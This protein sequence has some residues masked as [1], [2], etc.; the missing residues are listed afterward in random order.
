[1]SLMVILISSLVLTTQDS[2]AQAPPYKV[3]VTFDSIT[4]LDDREGTFSGDGEWDLSS[5]V[6]GKR[7]DLTAGTSGSTCTRLVESPLPGPPIYTQQ[8]YS[9][10]GLWNAEE[11]RT[12]QFNPGTEVTVDVP[13]GGKLL[14]VTTGFEIDNERGTWT[15]DDHPEILAD[16]AK[17]NDPKVVDKWGAIGQFYGHYLWSYN[18]APNQNDYLGFLETLY[19][20]TGKGSYEV[21]SYRGVDAEH[22]LDYR[23]KYT[24]SVTP[25]RNIP[26]GAIVPELTTC[27]NNLPISSATSSG[28][29]PTFTPA[30]AIDNNPNTKW[31]STLIIDPFITLDLGAS[32][33]VCGVDIAWADGNL[34]PYRFDVSVSTD[35]SS[36][37]D[38]FSGTS[39]GT[40]SSPEKYNF[41]QTQARYVKVTITESIAGAQRSIAQISEMDVFG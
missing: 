16:V 23:L 14:I 6:Q 13:Q 10:I 3:K 36:F 39:T 37:T 11:G 18:Q 27:T 9:C 38:A 25:P 2:Y 22:P 21:D 30:N 35:G 40:S 1:M 28:D 15:K 4:I 31:W 32:K 41:P 17:L 5:Y 20:L 7:V 26:P 29:Q 24:I 8:Q 33:S 34:H 12:Y 19:N